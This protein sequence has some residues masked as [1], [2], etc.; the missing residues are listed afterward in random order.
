MQW[1]TTTPVRYLWLMLVS[2]MFSCGLPSGPT[3]LPGVTTIGFSQCCDDAWRDVMNREVDREVGLHPELA[4]IRRV[5][6][7]DNEEQIRHIEELIDLGVDALLVSPNETESLSPVLERA[8]KSGIPVV[9]IDRKIESNLYT[10]YIGAD[11]YAI[12]FTAG[13]YL[14]GI[15]PEGGDILTIELPQLISPGSER[16][17]GFADAIA[18]APGLRVVATIEETDLTVTEAMLRDSL[19]AYPELDIVFG[20][21]DLLAERAHAIASDLNRAESLFFVGIDGIPGTGRGIEA[22]ED[23]IL[24]ASIL[25]PTG[26]DEAIRLLLAILNDLPYQKENTL[27]TI[28]ID[29]TNASILHNQMK[30]VD[31]LQDTVD[32]E[33]GRLESLRVIY[34]HQRL[35]ITAL[36]V[37]LLISLALAVSLFRSLRSK[38]AALSS[39]RE[40][41]RVILENERQLHNLADQLAEADE[42]AFTED[43]PFDVQ[44]FIARIN[45]L[46]KDR[47]EGR[48]NASGDIPGP[49]EEE[50]LLDPEDR[51]FIQRFVAAVEAHYPD[52]GFKAT[53]LCRELGL[54]RSQ[55]YR[56]VKALFHEG[57]TSYVE[58]VRLDRA[59]E[60]LRTTDTPVSEVA[61]AVGYSTPEYFTKVFKARFNDPPSRYREEFRA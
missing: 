1:N 13:Q 41:N 40:K 10:A 33:M 24:D 31:K 55:L 4:V 51:E 3:P 32:E 26:G 34:Q 39:V 46:L 44:V 42:D 36:L 45:A 60:L 49:V 21:T 6:H 5:A 8:Y 18:L 30:R 35:F 56:K 59:A 20:H 50:D 52:S 38:Q 14:A 54:S 7:S 28:V 58:R 47:R 29:S 17:R 27:E 22:V 2:S 25:Y 11:N 19:E 15:F 23:G 57:V 43:K 12:G 16:A 48:D 9:L 53:D 61:Y 37:M